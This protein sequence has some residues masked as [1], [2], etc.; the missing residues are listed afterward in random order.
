MNMF[1]EF[2]KFIK[3]YA[4][5]K[6]DQKIL[7]AISGGLDSVVMLHLFY[8]AGFK[9]GIAHADFQLRDQESDQDREFVRKLADGYGFVFHQKS[10]D[11]RN[12]AVSKKFSV[13]MAAR[14]LRYEW[15]NSLLVEK[16]YDFLAT[17]HHQNDQ[18]ETVLIN[19]IRGTGLRK[20]AEDQKLIWRE[21]SSNIAE[22]YRRN[23]LRHRVIPVLKEINPNLEPTI[24]RNSVRLLAAE[25]VLKEQVAFVRE[26]VLTSEGSDLYLDIVKLN[27]QA[28][29]YYFFYE[30]LHDFG[31]NFWQ[32]ENMWEK[33]SD[34]SGLTF[35]SK[36]YQA[37]L[38]RNR[39]YLVLLKEEV[40]S[41]QVA[42]HDEQENAFIFHDGYL[43]F[44]L[45]PAKNYQ[46]DKK[47]E[48]IALD[49]S[50]LEYPL[51]IRPWK[52]GDYF[53]PLGMTG[54]KKL[55]DFM[56]DSK[57]PLN[58]KKNVFLLESAGKIVWVVGH[59]LDNRFKITSDTE[60]ILEI[61]WFKDAEPI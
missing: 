49:Y 7:L 54:K 52:P 47:P 58:L 12:Y 46:P 22:K 42:V 5:F 1:Q 25:N 18:V 37:I 34:S 27:K 57:I 30:I 9:A 24:F 16:K 43:Q 23:F 2:Q 6:P 20:Y 26:Q 40:L 33:K 61:T 15:F 31:F 60:Q 14:E 45:M 3:K 48:K 36:L 13:E 39:I 35:N 8:R 17:A 56:I 41:P 50:K 44:K 29:Q 32:I 10:F 51:L 19:L 4:L 21:D 59:R 28:N 55:S 11:T 53:Y 38:D